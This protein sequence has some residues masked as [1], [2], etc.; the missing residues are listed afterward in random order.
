MKAERSKP[1][2]HARE[3][4]GRPLNAEDARAAG[5]RY[6]T[7][8]GPGIRRR[9]K[10]SGWTY[11]DPSGATIRAR[12]E[13]QRIAALAI[14]PAWTDVWI[15]PDPRGHIHASG[16]DARGRKQ[17]RYHALWRQ[18]RDT[19]KFGRMIEFGVALP[20][21]RARV[22]ELMRRRALSREMVLATVV[23]LL[24]TTFI[25]VGN[26]FYT[27]ENGTFGL[28]TLRDRHVTISG[29]EIRFRFKG[30]TGRIVETSVKDRRLARIV[31]E[32]QEIP[33]YEL[34][35]YLDENN[36]RCRVDSE[37]VNAFLREIAGDDFT[38]KDFRTWFGT[39]HAFTWLC[40]RGPGESEAETRRIAI[41][42]IDYVA[43][44]LRNTRAV[45]RASYVHPHVLH[46]HERGLLSE[47]FASGF[48]HADPP[49]GLDAAEAALLAL[50]KR[51]ERDA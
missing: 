18:V 24:E 50:L 49:E 14:P 22:E 2:S 7:D 26:E 45:S 51:V 44:Q 27:R 31:R 15:C 40:A 12:A 37:D 28:T 23:R 29:S 3:N 1:A 11:R 34:F 47:M 20:Q 48:D 9:R 25:R 5:L 6:V 10:G 13:R 43:E 33:G 36:E 16:R 46:G 41:E 30:K 17:Y 39:L 32:C 35:Q 19:A 38:A 4:G 8:D 42:A 21:M